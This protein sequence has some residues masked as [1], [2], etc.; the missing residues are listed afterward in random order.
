MN[1]DQSFSLIRL[2]LVA[3]FGQAFLRFEGKMFVREQQFMNKLNILTTEDSLHENIEHLEDAKDAKE[4][5]EDNDSRS[6]AA[7]RIQAAEPAV[8]DSREAL[9]KHLQMDKNLKYKLDLLNRI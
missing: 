1:Q 9:E 5:A 8:E 6:A 2:I 3:I 7:L 4:N